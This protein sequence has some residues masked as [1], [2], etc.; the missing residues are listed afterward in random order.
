MNSPSLRASVGIAALVLSAVLSFSGAL[1]EAG[2]N[3]ATPGVP[4]ASQV[5]K[6]G[7]P[8]EGN[9]QDLTY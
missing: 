6:N 4:E 3:A 5:F 1:R 8:A 9:V 2:P 7:Q